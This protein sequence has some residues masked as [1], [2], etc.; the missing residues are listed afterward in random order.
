MTVVGGNRADVIDVTGGGTSASVAGLAATVNITNAEGANDRLVVQALGRNDTV[1]ATALPADV[2]ELTLDGGAGNDTIRGSQGA[3]VVIGGDGNDSTFGDNGNDTAL[4][5]AGDDAFQWDPGDGSDTVEGQ[6]GRDALRFNGANVSE[7]IDIAANGGRVRFVR[8]VA[9]VTMDLD[10]VETVEFR[11]L[12]GADNVVVNDLSG[13]D[14]T[15]IDVDL[16]GVSGSG[17]GAADTVTVN[18]TQ[19]ADTFGPVG[20]AG[21]ID[22][23]G[24]HTVVHI[25][26]PEA[27]NDRL[28]LNALS[29]DDVVNAGSLRAGGIQLTENGGIGIDQLIGSEG[30]DLVNGGDGNDVA[31]MG[32]G[33]DAFV[34][35]PGDDDD[36]L[37]GQAGR[38]TMVFNGANVSE[39]IDIAAN[40]GRVRFFRNVANV[41]MDLNDVEDI[42]FA[43][44]GGSDNIVVNDLSGTD[45]DQ[46]DL[47]MSN[48]GAA[49]NVI[50]NA[51]N[52]DDVV[53]VNG[54]AGATSVVGL[55]ARV[56][57]TATEA[58][59]DR[60]TVNALAG[61]DVVEASGLQ[62]GAIQLTADGGQG[63]DVIIGGAGNDTLLGG[64]GDDVLLG[65]GGTDVIDGGDGDDIEIQLAPAGATQLVA[66]GDRVSSAT[67][68][69]AE[70]VMSHVRIVGGATVI[71]LAGKQYRLTG[72]DLS[73]LVA[74]ATDMVATSEPTAS[75][76]PETSEPDVP[77]PAASSAPIGDFVLARR[78]R[79]W[80]AGRRRA[81]DR[82]RRRP[83]PRQLRRHAGR[84]RHRPR[85]PLRAD[86]VDRRPVHARGRRCPTATARRW[87]MSVPTRPSTPTPTRARS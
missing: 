85:R 67:P 49:D 27:A 73:Q 30:D 23:R 81:R 62:A 74:A 18:G 7:N 37:E 14:L 55:P 25:D 69:D 59:N 34:W 1:T 60:L 5:G 65:G 16:A 71:D 50:V 54:D 40:G 44:L 68:A 19:G 70:W 9:N 35:N 39:N 87:S 84:G 72:T 47:A 53:L 36:T 79:R 17:D 31:L 61:D 6:D 33:D 86:A 13:T 21:G 64:P 45:V 22:V 48:D 28:V 24:L 29:G 56:N 82:R 10:D 58:A 52:G 46:V 66:S 15:A 42:A 43:A 77:S 32:A 12:G 57:I 3:D 80:P 2:I 20:D 11:A 41:T 38:D 51:T 8:D 76:E 63:N 26:A 83:A 75:S 78:R 4:L